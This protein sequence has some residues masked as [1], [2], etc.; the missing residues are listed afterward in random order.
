MRRNQGG[1]SLVE[2]SVTL[3]I[4]GVVGLLLW[5]LLP[6]TRD[7]AQQQA[8]AELLRQGQAAIEGFALLNHR[9][10]C[11]A[12]DTLGQEDCAA[13]AAGRVP[14]RALGLPRAFGEIR[15]GVH[16]TGSNDLAQAQE[17]Q[18]PLLPPGY[19]ANALN[20]L[21]F[22]VNLNVLARSATGAGFTAGGVPAAYALAHPGGDGQF[23]GLNVVGFDLPGRP[24]DLNYDDRVAAAGLGE[25]SGRLGC[26]VLLAQANVAARS[27]YAAYD[28]QRGAQQFLSFRTFAYAVKVANTKFA[29]SNFGIAT[30]GVASSTAKVATGIA[31]AANS[32]GVG[33]GTV[34]GAIIGLGGAVGV[35][36][37]AS[38]QL[39]LAVVGEAKA[40][41]Q[42]NGASA[43]AAQTTVSLVQ[44]GANAVAVDSR[45]L[46]P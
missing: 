38:V 15:Y 4:V 21:D 6:L 31:V 29:G 7:A 20:G 9:L 45:G 14:W 34:V 32:V 8:P 35:E 28:V 37:A 16:R 3:A 42:M 5:R 24:T 40:L 26:P 46:N 1:F 44:A 43:L 23:Q 11:A 36:V 25:L 41:A 13:G 27:A 17:R 22:C 2:L 30:L 39:A 19:S 12:N 18:T 33:V 10:P